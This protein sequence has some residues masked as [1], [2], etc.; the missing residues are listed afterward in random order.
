MNAVVATYTVTGVLDQAAAMRA[1]LAGSRLKLTRSGFAGTFRSTA[2]EV[3]AA[4]VAFTGYPA[5]GA[6]LAAWGSPVVAGDLAAITIAPTTQFAVGGAWPI[7][8]AVVGG[9]A[10]VLADGTL[11]A[12][13]TLPADVPMQVV[14]QGFPLMLSFACPAV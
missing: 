2:A 10:V 4:E 12:L 13:G 7:V 1:R 8:G 3:L 9:W 5:G 11:Y 14:G 6:T